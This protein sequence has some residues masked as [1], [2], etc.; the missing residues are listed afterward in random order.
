MRANDYERC[1]SLHTVVDT[2]TARKKRKE[3]RREV[4]TDRDHAEGVKNNLNV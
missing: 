1:H 2:I 4:E 3:Q